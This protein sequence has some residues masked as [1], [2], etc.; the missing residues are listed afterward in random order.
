[1]TLPYLP[2]PPSAEKKNKR[3]DDDEED[4]NDEKGVSEEDMMLIHLSVKH[5]GMIY[6][7]VDVGS[8]QFPLS[9]LLSP[10]VEEEAEKA[11]INNDD[12]LAKMTQLKEKTFPIILENVV[13]GHVEVGR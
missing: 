2:P 6:G 4:D 1:M 7:T 10:A 11:P 8:L 13:C 5:K 12:I 3:E 9:A